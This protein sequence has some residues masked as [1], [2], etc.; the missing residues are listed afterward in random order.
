[1]EVIAQNLSCDG[2]FVRCSEET[3]LEDTFGLIIESPQG[4]LIRA[5]ARKVWSDI[6]TTR[7]SIFQGVGVSFVYIPDDDR[8]ALGE[9]ICKLSK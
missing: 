1:M 4:R 2:A 3:D 6:F 9:M 8:D 7:D 5:L